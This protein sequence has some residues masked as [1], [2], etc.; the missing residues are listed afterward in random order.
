MKNQIKLETI[1]KAKA[2][3]KIAIGDIVESL[4]PI[5]LSLAYKNNSMFRHVEVSDLLQESFLAVLK[6]IGKFRPRRKVKFST[7]AFSAIRNA[8]TDYTALMAGPLRLTVR[9]FIK[10]KRGK[11]DYMD[12][13]MLRGTKYVHE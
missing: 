11:A 10:F 6:A 9:R 4:H 7:Y 2:G 8:Q 1:N 12:V 13:E 3:S 5:M